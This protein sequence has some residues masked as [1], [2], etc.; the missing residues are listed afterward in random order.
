VFLAACYAR[1]DP[2]VCEFRG[3]PHLDLTH[4][5]AVVAARA[6]QG[7]LEDAVAKR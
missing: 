4:Q 1:L 2:M 7:P 3:K 6:P 5:L